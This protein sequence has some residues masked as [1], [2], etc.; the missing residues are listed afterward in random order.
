MNHE[1][2]RTHE[3]RDEMPAAGQVVRG[4]KVEGIAT[5]TRSH[6]HDNAHSVIPFVWSVWSVVEELCIAMTTRGN[7]SGTLNA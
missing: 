2:H 5:W 4:M 3:S 1:T 6:I 7:F